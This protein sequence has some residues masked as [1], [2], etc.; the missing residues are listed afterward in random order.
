MKILGGLALISFLYGSWNQPVISVQSDTTFI[1]SLQITQFDSTYKTI[2]I[3]VALCDN[4]YQGIVPVPAKIGNG[5]DLKNNLYWGCGYGIRSYFKKSTEWQLQKTIALDTIRLERLIFKHKTK[6]YY[7]I[8]DAY[9]GQ[10]IKQCTIDFLKSCAGQL[11]DTVTANKTLLGI[12]GNSSL[13]A[14]IGHDGLMD[15][16]LSQTFTKADNRKRECIILAC[17]SKKYFA[18]HISQSGAYPLVWTTGL[19]CPEAYTVHDAIS[20]YVKGENRDSVRMKAAAAYAKY[21]KCG[22]KASKRLL[23]GGF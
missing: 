17:I 6:K 11:K 10:Y 2:H 3:L 1:Q 21:Q 14:Y 9:N 23:V 7:L 4:Q 12:N 20:A 5:K 13:L 18:P 19:M 16:T 22:L 15:F 8:A